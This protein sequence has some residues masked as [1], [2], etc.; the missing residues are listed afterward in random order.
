MTTNTSHRHGYP[1]HGVV[2]LSAVIEPDSTRLTNADGEADAINDLA[3]H[4]ALN[5]IRRNSGDIVIAWGAC[6]H[7]RHR[8]T[9]LLHLLRRR[10][11]LCL[12]QNANGSPRFPRAISRSIRLVEFIR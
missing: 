6:R 8:E 12:G 7:L 5:W 11:L 4:R 10:K 3:I 1:V 2:N 9:E